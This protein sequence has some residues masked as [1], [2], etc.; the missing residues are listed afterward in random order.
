MAVAFSGRRHRVVSTRS[1]IVPK[2]GVA[3]VVLSLCSREHMPEASILVLR[4]RS[5]TL[6]AAVRNS[7]NNSHRLAIFCGAPFQTSSDVPTQWQLLCHGNLFK[8]RS[9]IVWKPQGHA[10]LGC[11]AFGHLAKVFLD[12]FV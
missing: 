6:L 7:S 1:N 9:K 11:S 2:F 5:R 8:P 3:V 12:K 10:P 4:N